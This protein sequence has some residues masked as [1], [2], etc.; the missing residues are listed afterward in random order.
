MEKMIKPLIRSYSHPRWPEDRDKLRRIQESLRKRIRLS[1]LE[2]EPKFVAGVDAAFFG[3]K[4]ISAACVFT[5]PGLEFVEQSYL[6]KEVSFPYI[7][8]YLSFREGP[9]IIEAL[10]G[11][12]TRPDVVIFDGQGIAHPRGVG[13]ASYVGVLLEIPTVGCA[14]SRLIGDYTE[15]GTR[16]GSRR[17]LRHEGRV[18][19][20]VLRTRD[21]KRP[22]FVS[23]G[24]MI[25]IPGSLEVVL[26]STGRFRL[27]E[28]VRCADILSKRIK[29]SLEGR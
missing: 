24:H 22:V 8:G 9:A 25:D 13:I 2:K 1:P 17:A 29:R 4:V 12:K 19:G 23:P 16:K 28:P 18:V 15:P 5:Y 26:N 10:E 7:P 11:L 6:V 27:T 14:K 21:G 3:D 20:A